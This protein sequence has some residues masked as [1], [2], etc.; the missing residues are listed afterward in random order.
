MSRGSGGA[1][2]VCRRCGYRI[3]VAVR[4]RDDAPILFMLRCPRCGHVD[5]YGPGD[6]RGVA[7]KP[8]S[9]EEKWLLA[10]IAAALMSRR[11]P[12]DYA[13][14]VAALDYPL[15]EKPRGKTIDEY[16]GELAEKTRRM[17]ESIDGEKPADQRPRNG[18]GGNKKSEP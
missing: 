2:V 9:M 6:I 10:M 5:M 12:G 18:G 16:L 13:A 8:L 14:R 17:L 3:R 1:Y 7:E 15:R 4:D 11:S